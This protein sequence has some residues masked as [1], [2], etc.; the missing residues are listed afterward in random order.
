MRELINKEALVTQRVA[1]E[2]CSVAIGDRIP[3]V[4]ALQ[5]TCDASRG[6]VQKAL[7]N[8]KEA[9]AVELE[10]HG[11]SGTT[12]IAV[13]YLKLA[14]EC[15]LQH[16][17][18]SMPLPYTTRYEGLATALYMQL[19]VDNIRSYIIFQ[20]GSEAR[21]QMLLDGTVNYCVMSRL[22]FNE[23][24]QCGFDVTCVMDFG[25][26]SYVS[27]HILLTRD[28]ERMDWT[29]AKVGIDHSSVDQSVLTERFFRNFEVEFVP[30]QYIHIIE[31]LRSGDLDVGIWNEDDVHIQ[32][33]SEIYVRDLNG[34]NEGEDDNHAVIV[35]RASDKL[36]S[37]LIQSSINVESI[38]E[39]QARVMSGEIPACY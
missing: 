24:D 29:G 26:N 11:Q 21:L 27:R 22:A 34:L 12:L 20:R 30:V 15:G 4:S 38:R 23:F 3:T 16:L 28:Q 31:R 18:G 17:V 33:S 8:L 39:T 1:R 7:A 25:P 19:N 32:S 13:D 37:R 6:N 2:L 9:G 36:T 14:Q 35:A 10:S 5:E